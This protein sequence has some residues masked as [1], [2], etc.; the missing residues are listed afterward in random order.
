MNEEK[1]GILDV[2]NEV[3]SEISSLEDEIRESKVDFLQKYRNIILDAYNKGDYE[4]VLNKILELEQE[5]FIK[6]S[7]KLINRQEMIKIISASQADIR[8]ISLEE[9]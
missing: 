6:V 8:K 1:L 7:A 4:K 5:T 9:N 2:L 3:A